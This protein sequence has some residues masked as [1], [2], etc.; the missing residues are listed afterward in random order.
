MAIEIVDLPICLKTVMFHH[1]VC[2]PES[3]MVLAWFY[4]IYQVKNNSDFWG[5]RWSG[6]FPALSVYH[7]LDV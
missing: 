2:L 1:H 5:K 4:Q 3:I 7:G 6:V